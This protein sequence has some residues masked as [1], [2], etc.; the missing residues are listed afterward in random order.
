TLM[1]WL[2]FFCCLLMVYALG[3][4]LPKLMA[5]AGYSLGSSLSFLVALNLGGMFG[6]ILGGWLGDRF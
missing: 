6:A 2:A 4:W 3:S 5:N 1:I